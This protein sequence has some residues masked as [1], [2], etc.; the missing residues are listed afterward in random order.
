[1]SQILYPST[2]AYSG[3]PQTSWF[4][5]IMKYRSILPA[6]DDKNFT[7]T[8]KYQYRPDKLSYDKYN[9]AAYWWV[10]TVRNRNLISDPIWDLIVDLQIILP[11]LATIQKV[12][13]S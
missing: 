2:S 8:T 7:I 13:S 12:L 6:S 9:T 5:G 11:S 1:M 4:L 10:F 3:T